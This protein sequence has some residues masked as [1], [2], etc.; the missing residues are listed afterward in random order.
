[1]K[2]NV[3]LKPVLNFNFST[4]L[5]FKC[6][7]KKY[8]NSFING[9]LKFNKPR[10][11]I[12][13]EENG[14]KGQGDLLEGVV[15]SSEKKDN[16]EFIKSLKDNKRLE[17]F[18]EDNR[19]YF[20]KKQT[21]EL[22]CFCLYGLN[23]NVFVE[24]EVDRLGE[25]HFIARVNKKYFDD[26][27][28]N[29][30]QKKQITPEEGDKSAVIFINNPLVFF[31]K[32]KEFFIKLG[33]PK[34]NII[35]SPIDYVNLRKSFVCQVPEPLELLL[36]DKFFSNQ[37]EIRVVINSRTKRL[38]NYMEENNGVIDIG[39]ISDIVTI[40]DNYYNDLLLEKRG[41]TILFTL[42][43]PEIIELSHLPLKELIAYYIQVLKD[44]LPYKTTLKY[45]KELL[46][47]FE[48]IIYDK[49]GITIYN[50]DDKIT[51]TNVHGKIEE[52]WDE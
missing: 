8:A 2:N 9:K 37:S 33:I 1:M 5:L 17:Y 24:K 43:S 11:W 40:Y 46:N 20:R 16:S 22:Y 13:E 32:I 26:F 25:S 28:K 48:K 38:M 29:I 51:L 49:Y 14:N 15:L 47:E 36:K 34:E 41:N 52:L 18:Y 10:V 12:K 44:K 21:M 19:I 30:S 45:R 7:K 3:E 31:E 50:C 42:P 35:I 6:T 27:S 39:N 23:D 4:L